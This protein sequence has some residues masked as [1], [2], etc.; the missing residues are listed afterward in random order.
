MQIL[1]IAKL[2]IYLP[3]DISPVPFG[4]PIST[5]LMTS[6]APGV[7]TVPGYTPLLNDGVQLSVGVL[8]TATLDTGFVVGVTYYAVNITTAAGTFSLSTQKNGTGQPTR[9]A[10]VAGAPLTVHLMTKQTDGTALPFKPNNTVVAMNLTTATVF[11]QGAQDLNSVGSATYGQYGPY[12]NPTGPGTAVQLVAGGIP[13]LSAALV[14]LTYDW[15][16]TT[17]AGPGN[18]VLMQ[19]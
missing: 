8:S 12:G 4:D 17:S 1:N 10:A 5:A 6:A 15:L 7:F 18:L 19:N 9:Q 13:T 14:Q 2:P 16:L 3:Y 11:L